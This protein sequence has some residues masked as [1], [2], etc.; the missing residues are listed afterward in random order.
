[1]IE[2]W[3]TALEVGMIILIIIMLC[4]VIYEIRDTTD[5][6]NHQLMLIKDILREIYKRE[7]KNGTV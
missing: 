2:Y 1:M 6:I 4:R 3:A 7:D 5:Q